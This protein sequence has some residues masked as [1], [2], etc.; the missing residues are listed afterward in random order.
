MAKHVEI[1]ININVIS[2]QINI[3]KVVCVQKTKKP[4]FWRASCQSVWFTKPKIFGIG[5]ISAIQKKTACS[6]LSS[7]NKYVKLF[8]FFAVSHLNR[9]NKFHFRLSLGQLQLNQPFLES[10]IKSPEKYQ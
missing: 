9:N 1:F 3:K 4:D 2:T 7:V 5:R 10:C 8:S 6:F